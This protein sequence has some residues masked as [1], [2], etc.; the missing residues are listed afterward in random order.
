LDE[1][2][3]TIENLEKLLDDVK[4]AS[5]E[6]NIWLQKRLQSEILEEAIKISLDSENDKIESFIDDGIVLKNEIDDQ[7]GLCQILILKAEHYLKINK[8]LNE[9]EKIYLEAEKISMD[10]G[11]YDF[12]SDSHSGLGQVYFLKNDY[13]K[14]L[15]HFSKASVE[16]KIDD[17]IPNQYVAL[18][19]I[20]KILKITK[21]KEIFMEFSDEVEHIINKDNERGKFYNELIQLVE[22]VKKSL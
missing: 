5:P 4:N 14:S 15:A 1:E 18:I 16:S 10:I 13:T 9:V 8:D 6:E 22:L 7:E 12:A 19:G 21:D 20:H 11:S 17:N 2:N 3:K